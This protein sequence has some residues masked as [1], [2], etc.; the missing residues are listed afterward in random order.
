MVPGDK[1]LGKRAKISHRRTTL[2]RLQQ[3]APYLYWS[4]LVSVLAGHAF[5]REPM[6]FLGGDT[7]T[8]EP[9]NG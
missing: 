2:H 7:L 8:L 3:R 6:R 9:L 5:R 4:L 1:G